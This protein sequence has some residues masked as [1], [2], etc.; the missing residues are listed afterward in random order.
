MRTSRPMP[1]KLAAANDN[2]RTPKISKRCRIPAIAPLTANAEVPHQI[3]CKNERSL[4][5]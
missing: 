3:Q 4:H 2:T 1:P 5:L